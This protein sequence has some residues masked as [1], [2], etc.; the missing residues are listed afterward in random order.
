MTEREPGK[1]NKKEISDEAYK[2]VGTFLNITKKD[3]DALADQIKRF[4]GHVRVVMHPNALAG[5]ELGKEFVKDYFVRLLKQHIRCIHDETAEQVCPTFLFIEENKLERMKDTLEK[6]IGQGLE[7]NGLYLI[8]TEFDYGSPSVEKRILS[9]DF[10]GKIR[11]EDIETEK[12]EIK[13][14]GWSGLNFLFMLLGI[15]S[16]TASGGF[17]GARPLLEA[18]VDRCLG[19]FVEYMRGIL[20]VDISPNSLYKDGLSREYLKEVEFELKQTGKNKI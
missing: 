12:R 6:S 19:D 15:R 9:A 14:T 17:I 13:R 3:V 8:P 1:L 20:K 11:G 7:K 16:V 5:H 10:I 18:D 4:K 2:F